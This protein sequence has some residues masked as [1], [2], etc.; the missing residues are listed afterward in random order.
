[1]EQVVVKNLSGFEPGSLVVFGLNEKSELDSLYFQSNHMRKTFSQFPSILLF[2]R[3]HNDNGKALYT[4]FVD[5]PDVQLDADLM[6]VIHFAVPKNE[7]DDGLSHMYTAFKKFN[8]DW[9]KIK[10]ILVDPLFTG[11]ASLMQ[12]FPSID[13]VPSAFHIFKYMQQKINQMDL[14]TLDKS[15]LLEF[16]KCTMYSPTASNLK[17]TYDELKQFLSPE[18]FLQLNPHWLLTD[19]IWDVH[20]W[21]N[22]SEN[23]RY[24]QGL[25]IAC[26]DVYQIFTSNA[27]LESSI[28]SLAKHMRDCRLNVNSCNLVKSFA[29]NGLG[30]A[31]TPS[32]SE[33]IAVQKTP[34]VKN[35]SG[36]VPQIGY[37]FTKQNVLPKVDSPLVEGQ[38]PEDQ[39][40]HSLQNLC[41][42]PAAK[43]IMKEL[44]VA[45]NKGQIVG[46]SGEKI[47]VQVVDIGCV[48]PKNN[49]LL[50]TCLFSRNFQ[51]PCRHVMAALKQNNKVLQKE[52]VNEMWYKEAPVHCDPNSLESDLHD[53]LQ[54][55]WHAS[56]DK[57]LTVKFLTDEL[58]RLMTECADEEFEC[59]YHTLRELADYWIGPYEQVKL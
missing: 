39:V 15:R 8:P 57:F 20:C 14:N 7:F 33:D 28:T 41:T 16:L 26:Q 56:D 46:S 42:L 12:A 32:S 53:I 1:M 22:A 52:M 49:L 31:D 59:R 27:T 54:S 2:C 10:A 51:L 36:S 4:F 21:K 6:K 18:L 24:F 17:N 44:A 19:G 25:E 38:E 58:T 34:A 5:G 55:S 48:A 45:L 35:S 40:L 50:C 11:T 23:T 13:V 29:Q 9:C 3:T 37:G 47:N 30:S 43:L